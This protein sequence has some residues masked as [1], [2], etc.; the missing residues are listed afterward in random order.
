METNTV[1]G[2]A[3]ESKN[4]PR[5]FFAISDCSAFRH[6]DARVGGRHRAVACATCS[7]PGDPVVDGSLAVG[8]EEAR[9][10]QVDGERRASPLHGR[11]ATDVRHGGQDSTRR[12]RRRHAV[13][14]QRVPHR[15][16]SPYQRERR[17]QQEKKNIYIV[18]YRGQFPESGEADASDLYASACWQIASIIT[19]TRGTKKK[20]LKD[21]VLF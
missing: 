19:F 8:T 6:P 12:R 4:I 1:Y 16:A 11:A 3:R 10:A 14:R 21:R 9:G 20:K 7:P 17:A 15:F 18:T 2:K 5:K 13:S